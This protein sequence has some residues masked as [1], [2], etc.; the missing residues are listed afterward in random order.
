M[1]I[2]L[3]LM[4][5]VMTIKLSQAQT[6][7]TENSIARIWH[8]WTTKANA[9]AFE[10]VLVDEAIPGIEKNKPAG[11]KGIQLL[12]RDV[13][14]E[15]E[16]TTI[17]MFDSIESVKEFAG[18]DYETAHIDPKVKPLLLRYDRKSTHHTVLLQKK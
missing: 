2:I 15:I 11:Y 8:G 3:P 18:E 4:V 16:F 10:R 14:N 5:A 7:H 17:M 1:K 9:N 12:K 6:H 13:G